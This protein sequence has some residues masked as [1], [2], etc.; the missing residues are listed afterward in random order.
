MNQ[1]SVNNDSG[2]LVKLIHTEPNGKLLEAAFEHPIGNFRAYIVDG[3]L[4]AA[5]IQAHSACGVPVFGGHPF[6]PV[7]I[8]RAI[9]AARC[10][11]PRTHAHRHA[12]DQ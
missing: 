9:E 2:L 7:N 8:A 10:S 3:L 1:S 6:G 11:Q 12:R 4:I 5:K